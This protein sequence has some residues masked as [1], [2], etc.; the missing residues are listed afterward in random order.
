MAAIDKKAIWTFGPH[1]QQSYLTGFLGSVGQNL[2]AV[3][4]LRIC[5]MAQFSFGMANAPY[6]NRATHL[7]KHI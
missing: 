5:F 7:A 3:W 4:A 6:G 2:S 1:S